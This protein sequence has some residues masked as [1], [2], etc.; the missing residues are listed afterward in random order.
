[1]HPA[2]VNKAERASAERIDNELARILYNLGFPNGQF[3]WQTRRG[4]K[5]T[6]NSYLRPALETRN[7]A[8]QTGFGEAPST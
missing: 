2:S 8:A 7:V 1:M 6:R 3:P 5:N 4:S